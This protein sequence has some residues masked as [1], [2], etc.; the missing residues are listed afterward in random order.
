MSVSNT[1]YVV[2]AM[3]LIQCFNMLVAKTFGQLLK[4][5]KD[6]LLGMKPMNCTEIHFVGDR[7]D[8]DMKSLKGDERQRR[9]MSNI[10]PEY[11]PADNLK[12][13]DWNSYLSNPCSK[14]NLLS[15]LASCWS[16]ASWSNG[17]AVVLGVDPQAIR[18]TN[19]KI[20]AVKNLYCPNHEEADTRI[21]SH[22][23]SCPENSVVVIQATDT[24][25]VLLSMYYFPRLSNLFEIWV[26]KYDIFLPIHILVKELA[27]KVGKDPLV[28]TDT[29]LIGYVLSGCDSVSYPFKHGKRKAAKIPLPHIGEMPALSNA[30]IS[31]FA[32]KEHVMDGARIFF[33]VNSMESL[34]ILCQTSHMLTYL[35]PA[36]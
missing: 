29:L 5:Y 14:S 33:F 34:A 2:D 8:F 30:K 20:K 10:S 22:I 3:V 11:V 17:L 1:V 26:E 24:D 27:K 16:K 25:I 12:I 28:L 9:R 23:A 21:F 36:N 32:T 7:C 13:P 15:Y 19:T 6:K 35:H 31:D 18:V 4:M